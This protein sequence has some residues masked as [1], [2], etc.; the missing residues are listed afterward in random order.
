MGRAILGR[1][2]G[3]TGDSYGAIAE[4]NEV[5]VLLVVS[6]GVAHVAGW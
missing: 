1:I 5:L 2:P 4:L 6:L 3:L